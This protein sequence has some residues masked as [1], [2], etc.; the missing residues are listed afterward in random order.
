VKDRK[1]MRLERKKCLL[2]GNV[3][4]GLDFVGSS[5]A[6]NIPYLVLCVDLIQQTI[7]IGCY[8]KSQA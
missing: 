8:R 1:G 6:T 2:K 3:R 5:S 7:M 4:E